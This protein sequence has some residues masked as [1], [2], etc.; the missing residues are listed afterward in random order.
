MS[1]LSVPL[2]DDLRAKIKV[3]V[4]QG[5]APNEAEV[6]RQAIKNYLD[7]KAVEIVLKAQKEPSLEGDLDELADKL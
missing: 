7:E 3:L 1:T 5:Y 6:A 2:N 4:K